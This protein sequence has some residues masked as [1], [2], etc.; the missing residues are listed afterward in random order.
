MDEYLEEYI[1]IIKKEIHKRGTLSLLV[2]KI[3]KKKKS[4]MSIMNNYNINNYINKN[5]VNK[6]S[7]TN[8][9]N[10]KQNKRNSL[11]LSQTPTIRQSFN[12][13]IKLT[14]NLLNRFNIDKEVKKY[15]EQTERGNVLKKM[16]NYFIKYYNRDDNFNINMR[17]YQKKLGIE[18]PIYFEKN[19][20]NF[21]STKVKNDKLLFSKNIRK[22]ASVI[23]KKELKVNNRFSILGLSNFSVLGNVQ[24]IKENLN[25]K[26][27]EKIK[28]CYTPINLKRINKSILY[29][30]NNIII[31]DNSSVSKI[32]KSVN[33]IGLIINKEENNLKPKIKRI[34]DKYIFSKNNE[35]DIKTSYNR[36]NRILKIID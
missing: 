31:E 18:N 3:F 11:I 36:N 8:F 13:K 19:I 24:C 7:S 16:T 32:K 6:S 10:E 12:N 21:S 35:R 1:S 34:N 25:L 15:E 5:I 14:K 27:I 4:N 33:N 17:Y 9:N 2:K 20:Y 29:N 23:E 30:S 28:K 22:V 26:N